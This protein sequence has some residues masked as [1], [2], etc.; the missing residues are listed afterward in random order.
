M[1]W[2]TIN[3]EQVEINIRISKIWKFGGR[4]QRFQTSCINNKLK[5]IMSVIQPYKRIVVKWQCIS[6]INSVDGHG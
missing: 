3:C 5:I 1:K 4:Y 6:A 2:L